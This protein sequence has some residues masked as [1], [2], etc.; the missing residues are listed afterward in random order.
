MEE[1]ARIEKIPIVGRQVGRLLYQLAI[2][3]NAKRIF[4]LGSAFGYSAY[5]FAK[6]VGEDG[7]VYFTDLSK[8]NVRLAEEFI[9]QVKYEDIIVINLG[10]GVRILDESP[11]EYDIIFNDIEKED[12]HKVI[13]KS[14]K[15]LR[16][17][18]LFITDNVLWHGRIISDD[19]SPATEGVREFT[20]LLMSHKGFYTTI[21]P[22][23]DGLS[24]S[25]KL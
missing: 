6:A 19:K 13:D 25:V 9:K 11:G 17:G 23:R 1:L 20:R 21:L 24:V 15:K 5:W 18:G 4:E 22:I 2:I 7:R 8:N 12:Y 16:K 10:D 3:I 14:Y